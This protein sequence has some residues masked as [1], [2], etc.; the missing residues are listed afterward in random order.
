MWGLKM[1]HLGS[2][3]RQLFR[4]VPTT[5]SKLAFVN[6]H[7]MNKAWYSTRY[8]S[9]V[10]D[11]VEYMKRNRTKDGRFDK[12]IYL[13]QDVNFL[14][15]SY[16]MIKSK[17]G[18]MSVGTDNMTFDGIS[19]RYIENLSKTLIEGSYK[20]KP[21]R[22]VEIP[23]SNGKTRILGVGNPRQKIVQ[24]AMYLILN[25]IFEDEF[26][27]YNHGFRPN[28]SCHTALRSLKLGNNASFK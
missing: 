25:H 1:N 3:G 18:N 9:K 17:P 21:V 12:L 23:K 14:T 13:I 19:L 22:E 2:E 7:R 5:W 6:I 27:D 28:R 16:N 20:F 11:F 15:M 24:Q 26:L 8:N 10:I 4:N